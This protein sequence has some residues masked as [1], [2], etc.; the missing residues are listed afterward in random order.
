MTRSFELKREF[1]QKGKVAVNFESDFF[2]SR[3]VLAETVSVAIYKMHV[4]S[5]RFLRMKKTIKEHKMNTHGSWRYAEVLWR[6]MI[7]LC[8][9]LK[10]IFNIITCN[11]EPEWTSSPKQTEPSETVLN[12]NSRDLQVTQSKLT[13]RRLT[14]TRSRKEP[15]QWRSLSV[16]VMNELSHWTE[17]TDRLGLTA[18]MSVC[19]PNTWM[20]GQ[21]NGFVLLLCLCKKVSWW[22]GVYSLYTL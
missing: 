16:H 14:V 2:F 20:K 8:K 12:S 4:N 3:T 1:S 19:E 6:N 18:D 10:I 13:F 17:E 9:K 22:S 11:P 21:M 7:G 5:Y 15:K